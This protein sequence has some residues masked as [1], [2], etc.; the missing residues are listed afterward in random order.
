MVHGRVQGD[1]LS[2]YAVV[3][4]E[5][6]F[7]PSF[8]EH[9]RNMGIRQFIML[10]DRSDDG[11]LDFLRSQP[12]CVILASPLR[13]GDKIGG[14][15][16]AHLWKNWIPQR[17]FPGKWAICADADEFIFFPPQFSG[18]DQ[19]IA[20][21]DRTGTTAVAAVMVDFYPESIAQMESLEAPKSLSD[22]FAKYA[23]FDAGPYYRWPGGQP[24]PKILHGGVRERLLRKFVISKR[25]MHKTSFQI[26]LRRLKSIFV[27]D[28]NVGSIHKVPIVK[29]TAGREYLHSH[30]LNEAPGRDFIL[31]IAHFK[32]TSLLHQK[33]EQAIA[34][35]AYSKGSRTYFAYAELLKAMHE[36]DGSFLDARS[37][38]FHGVA[39]FVAADLASFGDR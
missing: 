34:S 26:L 16:A 23:W 1:V 13:Y 18:V 30:T 29:W 39:D 15:R 5:M 2:V 9:Y 21:L 12:D 33:I 32:F 36:C 31:P 17:F 25:D 8:F 28:R 4:N 27:K 22:L 20:H 24:R 3:R 38:K 11:S 37:V 7:L 14:R 35:K 10:D 19:F 6:F